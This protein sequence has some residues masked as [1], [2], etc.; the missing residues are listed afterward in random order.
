VA[1]LYDV[2]DEVKLSG[3]FT[4]AAGTAT[5]PTAVVLIVTDP[6]DNDIGYHY[7]LSSQ[8]SWDA[9]ANS[10]TLA[11]G[12]GTAGHYYTVSTAGSTDFGGGSI[13]FTTDDAVYYNGTVWQNGHGAER[14][15]VVLPRQGK[16]GELMAYITIED[17]KDYMGITADA[18]DVLLENAIDRAQTS[19]ETY[20]GKVFEAATETRYY[21]ESAVYGL[22]L[23]LD[24]PL[25]TVTTLLEGDD[26]TTADKTTISSSDYWLEPRNDGPP[27]FRIRLKVNATP[28]WTFTTDG[29]IE[30]E[31]TWGWS[32]TAPN[33]IVQ[34]CIRWAAY[35]YE[36]KDAP[37]TRTIA[38]AAA[39][40]I[41]VPESIPRDIRALLDPYKD[42]L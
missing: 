21:D 11:D 28:S 15:R 20:T 29:Y 1:N 6:S 25:L 3:A 26:D 33:D 4:N 34:A 14:R 36:Q 31:G 42:P 23:H 39:G 5:D 16:E 35:V 27:Y 22:V 30:V 12:T 13:T 2:S 17:V 24:R 37:Y 8:G 38:N 40:V 19:I 9:D 18:D 7:G 32:T 10:P 41:E